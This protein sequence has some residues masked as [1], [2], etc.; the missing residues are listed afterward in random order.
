MADVGSVILKTSD[1]DDPEGI[2]RFI[3][4]ALVR[5]RVVAELIA[6]AKRRGHVAFQDVNMDTVRRRAMELPEEGIPPEVLRL[7]PHDLDLD[8]VQVQKAATPVEGRTTV[9]EAGRSIG[10]SVP[11][12]VVEE[13]SSY[14]E[15]D[16]NAQRVAAIRHVVEALRPMAAR[17]WVEHE[18][19][20]DVQ[21]VGQIVP[22][23]SVST[24]QPVRDRKRSFGA[25]E[26]VP[27]MG[28]GARSDLRVKRPCVAGGVRCER[29]RK[30]AGRFEAGASGAGGGDNR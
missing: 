5:R 23:C 24:E 21:S 8:W 18:R 29:A 4:Q 28:V 10:A 6:G 13:R 7:V 2:K 12:A 17:P 20:G 15:A 9:E 19:E 25:A 22:R 27:E 30:Q 1:E 3:T 14:A 11:N 16:A 26:R